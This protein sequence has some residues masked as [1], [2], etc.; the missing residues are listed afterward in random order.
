M[1]IIM[2]HML[3]VIGAVGLAHEFREIAQE[4]L[5]EFAE[6]FDAHLEPSIEKHARTALR[7]SARCLKAKK[8][9]LSRR[10]VHLAI[11]LSPMLE[12]EELTVKLLRASA[13]E[14]FAERESIV[15]EIGQHD[16]LLYR[17]ES[18]EPTEPYDPLIL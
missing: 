13:T 12:K 11:A 6:D 5:P 4:R 7:Y 17:K 1:Q 9:C 16:N 8:L 3:D 18:Y 10:Y 2:V 15:N 14:N